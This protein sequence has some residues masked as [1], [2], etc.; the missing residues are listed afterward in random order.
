MSWLLFTV[1]FC[2]LGLLAWASS[3]A[4][5]DSVSEDD[6]PEKGEGDA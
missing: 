2:A 6:E 1:G 5:L 4:W 3:A